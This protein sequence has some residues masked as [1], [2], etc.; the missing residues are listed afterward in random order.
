ML[1][2]GTKIEDYSW[3]SFTVLGHDHIE[4]VDNGKE[5]SLSLENA[6][7]FV[8]LV[9][10]YTFHEN[11]KMQIQ[12]FKKGFNTVFPISSLSPFAHPSSMQDE[13]QE[14]ICGQE[15]TGPDW[16]NQEKLMQSI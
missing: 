12:A 13:L 15:C 6:Q 16:E 10:H 5:I 7:D 1:P 14:M 2:D 8:N 3:V 9:L 4:M 11:I